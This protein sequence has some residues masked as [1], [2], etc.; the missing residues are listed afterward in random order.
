MD[1]EKLY[2]IILLFLAGVYG[3]L[4]GRFIDGYT[5]GWFIMLGLTLS[6][7]IISTLWGAEVNKKN[8][9]ESSN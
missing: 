2:L 3:F 5:F 4:L 9:R 1:K 6:I 7:M 8:G